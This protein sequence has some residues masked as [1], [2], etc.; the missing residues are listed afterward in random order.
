VIR[1]TSGFPFSVDNGQ[2]WATNWDEQ[3]SGQLIGRPQT[4]VF[5]DPAS[6][7]VSVFANP[8]AAI[9]DFVH[10]FPGQSGSRNVLRGDGYASWDMGLLKTFNLPGEGQTL[11][12]R[13]EV[14]N[15]ANLTRFNVLAGLGDGAPSL[16]QV[17]STFGAYAGLLTNP[18]VMQFAL[19]YQF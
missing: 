6:G 16:Q 18:R 7:T 15:V 13:W 12:F 19:R 9:N 3:G 11:Q 4:G 8:A 17:P 1:W 2:F 14:F 5:K 10:P